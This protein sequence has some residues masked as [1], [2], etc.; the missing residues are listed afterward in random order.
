MDKRSAHGALNSI[1]TFKK[2]AG[3]LSNKLK[4]N[5]VVAYECVLINI[6]R[7]Y[8]A[9]LIAI[10][11]H[12]AH[13]LLFLI[14]VSPNSPQ[15]HFWQKSIIFSH[16]VLLFFMVV[17]FIMAR[18]YRNHTTPATGMYIVQYFEVLLLMGAGVAIAS[19]DQLVT[20]N[21]TPFLVVICV[22]SMVFLIRPLYTFLIYLF[23]YAAFYIT[24]GTAAETS[25]I[26][27]SNRVNGITCVAIGI[28]LSGIMWQN[29]SRNILQKQ[30]IQKQQK[31]LEMLAH[32]DPLTGL[33]NRRYFDR[34]VETSLMTVREKNSIGCIIILDIDDF[35]KINDTYGHIAGDIAL[36]QL[37]ILLKDNL[38]TYDTISRLGGEEF[39]MLLPDKTLEE[40]VV[41]TEKLRI[42][43]EQHTFILEE[44]HVHFTASFG[45][46]ILY[47]KKEKA[48]S[49]YYSLADR[50][51]YRAK[52]NGKNRVETQESLNFI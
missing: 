2:I 8:Y 36:I 19:F 24:I 31:E 26:L 20:S 43:I 3:N 18:Y 9:A 11:V 39:I 10:P 17:L 1:I 52:R 30:F 28:V 5:Q 16:S 46:S 27:A 21:V 29:N 50:A 44:K 51:L 13:I 48:L 7:L 45:V 33:S 6:H 15:Q 32:F 34:V 41:I 38:T 42:L 23:S 47:D 37:A 4:I 12:I 25:E 35:K 22:C 14:N 49:S 40:S